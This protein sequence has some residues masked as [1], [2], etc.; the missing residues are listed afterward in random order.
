LFGFQDRQQVGLIAAQGSA[1]FLRDRALGSI[2]HESIFTG[3][4]DLNAF[5][6]EFG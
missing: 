3:R 5:G 6:A 2:D 4:F 1:Q